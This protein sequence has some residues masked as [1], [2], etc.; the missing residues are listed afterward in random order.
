MGRLIPLFLWH[1]ASIYW[2]Y[3]LIWFTWLLGGPALPVGTVLLVW[4]ML[5]SKMPRSICDMAEK[6]GR[7]FFFN[8]KVLPMYHQGSSLTFLLS[9]I[10]FSEDNCCVHAHGMA[11]IFKT[12]H[13]AAEER[14]VSLIAVCRH[15][16]YTET[17]SEMEFH[18]LAWTP[19]NESIKISWTSF[20]AASIWWFGWVLT[21]QLV[22]NLGVMNDSP[23]KWQSAVVNLSSK[24]EI[25][26]TNLSVWLTMS[27][28]LSLAALP[29]I[30]RPPQQYKDL[31]SA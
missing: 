20:C 13:N 10:T 11:L 18:Y 28:L 15:I 6:K 24:T 7:L 19:A 22:N 9:V 2:C 5:L 17:H 25:Q 29:S 4:W 27:P 1:Q 12:S 30:I 14:L 26:Y 8:L 31:F 21:N 3:S 16:T 23:D